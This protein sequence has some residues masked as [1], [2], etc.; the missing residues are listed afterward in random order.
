ML[1]STS[2]SHIV[3]L[4]L[5]PLIAPAVHGQCQ[6]GQTSS[7][8]CSASAPAPSAQ[9]P[10]IPSERPPFYLGTA[11]SAPQIEG[12]VS[13]DGRSQSVWDH[14]AAS[15]GHIYHNET[16][17]VADNFFHRY[18]E[19]I[20]LMQRLGLRHFRFSVAWP[21]VIPS[22]SGAVST[23][24]LTFY[25]CVLDK[26]L[27]ANIQPVVTLYHWDLPQ[28]LQDRYGGWLSDRVVA[29]YLKFANAVFSALGDR[30]T[31]WATFNEP[32]TFCFNGYG[33]GGHAP[34]IP[35]RSGEKG[36]VWQ[37]VGN[38]LRSHAAA[39]QLFRELVP[40]GKIS[41][42]LNS[43]WCEPL[44]SSAEDKEAAA[45][46][47]DFQ[48]SIFADPIYLGDWPKSVKE[49]APP[50]LLPIT[51]DLA[52]ALNGTSDLFYLN[53]YT[54]R[55]VFN[56][57][58][59]LG[60]WSAGRTD[61]NSTFFGRDRKPI[62]GETCAPDWFYVTPWAMRKM[63]N[64]V[65]QRYGHPD[66]IITE[67]GVCLP[68]EAA[69]LPGVLNDTKLIEFHRDYVQSAMQA[70]A[71]DKVKVLGYFIWSIYDNWEWNLGT[72]DRFGLVWVDFANEQARHPKAS[73]EWVSRW[74]T[75]E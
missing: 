54:A 38:V 63:L 57:P 25:S 19:D 17:N 74:F 24:G 58:G 21:R 6:S 7:G 44:T 66:I 5:A 41:M 28:V 48:I 70:V 15:P 59:A 13:T 73:T 35:D 12:A 43:D 34:G 49:R 72:S 10:L 65:D 75:R 20:A 3:W 62:G 27:A 61:T 1:A 31:L 52:A 32:W 68:G 29:D 4:G 9:S 71:L 37:C 55:Y 26:L 2:N 51:P 40:K 47:M 45:R 50:N 23:E 60:E 16:P 42:A 67:N 56:Q 11:T 33:T 36:Q 18:P 69:T 46:Q 64:W 22:G 14:W 8:A 53:F 39:V 30:V